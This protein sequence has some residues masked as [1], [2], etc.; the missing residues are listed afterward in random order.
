MRTEQEL[1]DKLRRMKVNLQA[2]KEEYNDLDQISM[3]G[4]EGTQYLKEINELEG[5]IKVLKWSLQIE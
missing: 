3:Q 5:A 4:N 1:M 2:T